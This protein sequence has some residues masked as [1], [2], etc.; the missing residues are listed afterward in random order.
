MTRIST[1]IA[2]LPK[3]I[4]SASKHDSLNETTRKTGETIKQASQGSKNLKPLVSRDFRVGLAR[5]YKTGLIDGKEANNRFISTVVHNALHAKL[6]E[7][8]KQGLIKSIADFF[9]ED[10]DFIKDLS[11]NLSNLS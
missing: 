4:R 9:S 8:D 6:S 7:Q 2:S 11:K 10:P 5:E 3:E 1:S